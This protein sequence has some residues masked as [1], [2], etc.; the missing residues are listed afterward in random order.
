MGLLE[1]LAQTGHADLGVD[2]GR[3]K[4]GVAEKFLDPSEIG[5]PVEQVRGEGVPEIVRGE[6]PASTLSCGP[7]DNSLD[8][9]RR[10]GMSV[11]THECRQASR[12]PFEPA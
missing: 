10:E 5:A 11:L 8:L 3:R 6:M 2:L 4:A 12:A 7:G 1:T 9:T